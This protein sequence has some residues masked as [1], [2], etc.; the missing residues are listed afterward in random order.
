MLRQFA[1]RL[2]EL[3]SLL[4]QLPGLDESKKITQEYPNE[5]LLHEVPHRWQK[6]K[7]ITSSLHSNFSSVCIFLNQS[8]KIMEHLLKIY[9][10]G[11]I[12]TATVSGIIREDNL[13]SLQGLQRAALASVSQ[14]ILIY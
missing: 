2:K 10:P 1:A 5:I 9:I 12:T 11:H 8:T 3:N 13:N 6:K 7:M 4:Q 14:I